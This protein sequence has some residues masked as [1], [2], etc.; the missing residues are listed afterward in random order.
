MTDPPWDNES[1]PLYEDVALA[2]TRILKPSGFLF[3]YT[4]ND[5]YAWI[6]DICKNSVG[7]CYFRTFAGIQENS[8]DMYYKK[9]LFVKWRPILVMTRNPDVRPPYWTPDALKTNRDKRFHQWGQGVEPLERWIR[10]LTRPGDVVLDPFC[11]GGAT[12]VSAKTVGRR[13]LTFEI[14]HDTAEIAR[15]RIRETQPPLFVMDELV[16]SEVVPGTM[17]ELPIVFTPEDNYD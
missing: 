14:D 11:G 6:L 12:A 3:M 4:G 15:R 1:L 13:W 9:A 5:N 10:C 17:P 2:A 7:L 8:D 16:S